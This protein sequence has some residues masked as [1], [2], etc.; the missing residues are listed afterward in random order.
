MI[1]PMSS[2]LI[3]NKSQ[4]H[5]TIHFEN[6]R[7]GMTY[8]PDAIDEATGE[9][10]EGTGMLA[11]SHLANLVKQD[12]LNFEGQDPTSYEDVSLE[13]DDDRKWWIDED[14]DWVTDGYISNDDLDPTELAT[15]SDEIH[16]TTYAPDEGVAAA[17][18]SVDMG[19]TPA[20]ITVQYLSH[21]V[22]SGN[23]SA[24]EA[25]TEALN[26]GINHAE[27]IRSFNY[28]KEQFE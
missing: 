23:I 18:A 4:K 24:E 26:S 2:F 28:L 14:G 21:Q 20:D 7:P 5:M 3:H 22:Y 12:Q 16:N 13:E 15:V 1:D 9:R 10:V 11:E 6:D 19:N 25:F 17:V 8:I 27:L